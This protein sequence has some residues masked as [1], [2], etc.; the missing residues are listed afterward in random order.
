M[1]QKFFVFGLLMSLFLIS[2]GGR[3][4]VDKLS[5]ELDRYPEYSIVLEDMM[6]EGNFFTDYYHK[7]KIIYGEKVGAEDS[8]TYHNLTTD[9]IKV[10]K[11]D[12]QKYYDNLGMVI[13]SKSADGKIN[14]TAYPPG[15]NYVGNPRYGQWR[16]DASGNSFW[17]FYGKYAFFSSM[18]NM[19]NRPVYRNDW[20]D[21]RSYRGS[22][23]P[24][25]GRGNAYGTRGSYTKKTHNSFFERRKERLASKKASFSDRVQKRM[26]RS[27]MSGTRRRSGGFGK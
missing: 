27:R 20:N 17:E 3:P 13:A 15:Y 23:R 14:T 5:R 8:L 10:E 2:C 4:G 6:E 18:F 16:Q 7:Y 22:G 12:F 11:K 24:Y 26:N 25:Y 19:F 9:W 21:Y 1:Y